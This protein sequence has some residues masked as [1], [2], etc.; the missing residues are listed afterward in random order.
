[1]SIFDCYFNNTVGVHKKTGVNAYGDTEYSPS[2]DKTPTKI[3]CRIEH[4]YKEIL[5][6]DGNK[7]TSEAMLFTD[8][9]LVPLDIVKT[10]DGHQ[11]TVKVCKPINS[12]LGGLDH[13]EVYL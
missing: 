11:Y 8:T 13:Y 4:K 2:L 3:R 9:P 1:M 6:K 5:D 10:A 7:I 12:V